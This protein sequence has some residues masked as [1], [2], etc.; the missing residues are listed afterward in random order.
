MI[1]PQ[2][3][4]PRESVASPTNCKPSYPTVTKG[5]WSGR[6]AFRY[7]HPFRPLTCLVDHSHTATTDLADDFKVAQAFR[8]ICRFHVRQLLVVAALERMVRLYTCCFSATTV[9]CLAS[10]A[11]VSNLGTRRPFGGDTT[12]TESSSVKQRVPSRNPSL[13]RTGQPLGSLTSVCRESFD[14]RAN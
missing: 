5:R 10:P 7:R 6:K 2:N 4:R 8:C 9:S 3:G 12:Q 13:I 11:F 14:T 1:S